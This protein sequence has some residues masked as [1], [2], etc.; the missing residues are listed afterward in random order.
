MHE[1]DYVNK[2]FYEFQE[3]AEGF[4]AKGHEVRVLHVR[5]SSNTS[6]SEITPEIEMEGL[7]VAGSRI[8]LYSPRFVVRGIFT[9]VLAVFEH[10][11]LL[12]KIFIKDRPNVV[13]SYSVPT[14]GISVAILGKLFGVPVIH[15]AIDVSH[16]L[17]SKYLAPVVKFSEL[18]TFLMSDFVST[19]N[20]ALKNYIKKTTLRK[21]TASIELPPVFPLETSR[22]LDT[23]E[24]SSEV[25]MIFIGFLGHFTDL[26]SVLESMA[27]LH[28]SQE[29]NL[30][31]VGAGPQE[32]SLMAITKNFGLESRVEFRGWKTRES[33]PDELSWANVGIVPF[34]KNLLTDCALPQKA[35]EYLS[36]G[37]P[38][39]STHLEGAESVLG[40]LD[41]FHSVETCQEI[42]QICTHILSSN[43]NTVQEQELVKDKFSRRSAVE[44]MEKLLF[45]AVEKRAK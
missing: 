36:A 35:I 25:R 11:R 20:Q 18:F 41:N 16:L 13:L 42:P 7:H 10:F 37:L 33:F 8:V 26:E 15:R 5:E 34:K 3:F 9:R 2:P 40:E 24:R 38:V 12:L 27:G 17:N 43:P 21:V 32:E 39:V 45:R 30:R 6:G 19:H 23:V 44:N 28:L 29:I 1:V 31:I 14:S 22:Q 4:S